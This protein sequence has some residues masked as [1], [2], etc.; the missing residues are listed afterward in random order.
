MDRDLSF[1]LRVQ[2]FRFAAIRE[3]KKS[4]C[5]ELKDVYALHLP[6]H[7]LDCLSEFYLHSLHNL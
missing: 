7:H 2:P 3:V 6:R 1:D 5:C 4:S